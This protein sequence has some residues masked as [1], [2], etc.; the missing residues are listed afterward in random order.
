MS[1]TSNTPNTRISEVTISIFETADGELQFDIY[2]CSP[3]EVVEGRDP[4]DGGI[5]SSDMRNAIEM[6]C[7]QAKDCIDRSHAN[8]LKHIRSQG[9]THNEI[10]R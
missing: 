2:A 8:T 4:D 6:A 1:N 10:E 5:C 3:E 7:S 9:K